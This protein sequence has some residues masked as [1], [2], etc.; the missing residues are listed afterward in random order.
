MRRLAFAGLP[1]GRRA[2]NAP[3]CRP[4]PGERIPGPPADV[5]RQHP[6]AHWHD[7]LHPAFGDSAQSIDR[8]RPT[9]PPSAFME[10]ATA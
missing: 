3:V 1:Y 9:I 7:N 5:S 10:I 4:C 6:F 2:W 8:A